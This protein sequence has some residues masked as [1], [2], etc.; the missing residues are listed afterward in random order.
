MPRP[1]AKARRR[2]PSTLAVAIGERIR[3]AR[4]A[5][6]MTARALAEAV[7]IPAPH[8]SN[9]ETGRVE[10]RA[11]TLVALARALGCHP[12][13]LLPSA[14]PPTRQALRDRVDALPDPALRD[15]DQLLTILERAIYRN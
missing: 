10:P 12:G 14:A 4:Q 11:S 2:E 7:E 1:N 5:R 6:G 15:L 13:E 9:L 3:A 8:L